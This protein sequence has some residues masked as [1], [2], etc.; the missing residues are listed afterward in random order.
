M[1][2]IVDLHHNLFFFLLLILGLVLYLFFFLLHH[3]YYLWSF[4]QRESILSFQKNY[5]LL[6]SLHHGTVIELIW[7]LI[8]SFILLFIAVPSFCLLYSM[9]EVIDPR[10]TLKVIGHQW[11]WTYEYGDYLKPFSFD[12]YMIPESELQEG[13]LRLL[14]TD[15]R[16][17]LPSQVHIRLLISSSDVLHS[18]AI[19]S[20]G[21]KV[22]AVPGR[23]NQLSLYIKR[24]G[25][26]YGQ[27][28]ELCGVNHGFMPISLRVVPLDSYRLFVDDSLAEI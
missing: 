15:N 26:Y 3:F 12:S 28:S 4:P 22:D 17:V 10:I 16:F 27:C 25:F 2:G 20:L 1:E 24:N 11:Y 23:L 18:F 6:N 7:T 14:E 8:P 5:L 19:P 9:D 13:Q 21:L